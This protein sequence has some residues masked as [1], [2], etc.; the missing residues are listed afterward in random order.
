MKLA[1]NVASDADTGSSSASIR[2]SARD[3]R[4]AIVHSRDGRRGTTRSARPIGVAHGKILHQ[5]R[6]RHDAIR[7]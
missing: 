6:E 4:G 7:V 5:C 2:H 1:S 3:M